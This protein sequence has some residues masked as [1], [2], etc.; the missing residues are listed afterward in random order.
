M[1]Y[2][3]VNPS[4]S[5]TIDCPDLAI[6]TIACCLLGGGQYGFVPS[7][8]GV[9]VPL[10]LFG[11]VEAFCAEHFKQPFEMVRE[12]VLRDRAAAL[13]EAFDSVLIGRDPDA[14]AAFYASV[15]A[16]ATREAFVA[17]RA[18][19]N[20]ARRTSMNDIGARAYALAAKVRAGY[21]AGALPTAPRQVF[22]R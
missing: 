12:G 15:P 11:G 7:D 6:A 10:F 2:E 4:D 13:A 1:L 19:Y 22:G 17:L 14:R 18:Q 8:G 9:E 16:D 21:P 20:D 5:Y 3:I